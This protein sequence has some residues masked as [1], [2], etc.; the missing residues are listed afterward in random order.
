MRV[1]GVTT[2]HPADRLVR[3][4]LTVARLDE[5]TPDD[6]GRLVGPGA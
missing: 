5:L 2:T 4:H 1:V 3:A 6:V